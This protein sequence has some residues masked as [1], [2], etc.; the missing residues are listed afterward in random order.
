MIEIKYFKTITYNPGTPSALCLPSSIWGG[1]PMFKSI[2]NPVISKDLAKLILSNIPSRGLIAIPVPALSG[3]RKSKR[4][5]SDFIPHKPSGRLLK[6][7]NKSPRLL[8]SSGVANGAV[9][10]N[11]PS[12]ELLRATYR[13]SDP[14]MARKKICNLTYSGSI[15]GDWKDRDP[16]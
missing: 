8:V 11:L 14:A 13:S 10:S 6:H 7:F 16:V 9:N 4:P 5:N 2:Q 1:V 15:N 12:D 3:N